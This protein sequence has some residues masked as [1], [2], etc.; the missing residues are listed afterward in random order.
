VYFYQLTVK[1]AL[2]CSAAKWPRYFL[3]KMEVKLK[4]QGEKKEDSGTIQK[5][6]CCL[7]TIFSYNQTS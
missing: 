7:H 3:N 1:N 4:S 5:H 6:F 2:W